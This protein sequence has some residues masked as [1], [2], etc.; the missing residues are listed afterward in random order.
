VFHI[1]IWEAWSFVWGATPPVETGLPCTSINN[2]PF[3]LGCGRFGT[4]WNGTHNLVIVP[5]VCGIAEVAHW[6][7]CR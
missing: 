1:S 6:Q 5:V 4:E 7:M 3:S 2:I